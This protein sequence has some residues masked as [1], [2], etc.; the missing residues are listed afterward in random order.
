MNN[1]ANFTTGLAVA[2]RILLAWFCLLQAGGAGAACRDSVVLVHGN[3]GAPG[4]WDNTYNE[5]LAQ[6]YDAGQIHRPDWG[7]KTCAACNNHSGSE[8]TPVRNAIE[9]AIA[10]SCSG[11]ID[12]IGH[13]MGVTLAAQ[14]IIKLGRQGQVDTF[15]GV[16]GAYRGLWTC[17]TYPFNV[18]NSTCGTYGL[19]VSS[20]FLDWLYGRNIAAR[21]YS[22]K[23]WSDQIVCA[24]GVCTVGG[25]HS[26][27]I[28]GERA[29]Y[30]Y[31]YGHF[32]LQEYTYDR[33]VSLIH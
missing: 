5:L 27:R 18:Y 29:T 21:V 11:K 20:P 33:Q 13:S 16:A 26:S 12:V 22:I 24:T 9:A 2:T 19:S 15:V 6:G 8:E 30:S 3:T 4:D 31:P 7:S 25:I 1:E 23:S 17:G 28:A 32:G 10:G 14:Q